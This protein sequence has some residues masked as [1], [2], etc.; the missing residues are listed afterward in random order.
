MQNKMVDLEK[1]N[2]K[3]KGYLPKILNYIDRIDIF[4]CVIQ[5]TLIAKNNITIARRMK[6]FKKPKI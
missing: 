5:A 6:I 1:L 3:N 4:L 2:L